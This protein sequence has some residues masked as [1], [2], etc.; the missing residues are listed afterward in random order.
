MLVQSPSGAPGCAASERPAA[1]RTPEAAR[2]RAPASVSR[3]SQ[4]SLEY[5]RNTVTKTMAV[6]PVKTM[7][8]TFC[9]SAERPRPTQIVGRVL[10][11]KSPAGEGVT[12]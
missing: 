2:V 11:E 1:V 8:D 9:N 4:P 3:V 10:L 12:D 5:L 7:A 6:I